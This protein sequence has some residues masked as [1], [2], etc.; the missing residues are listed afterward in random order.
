MKYFMKHQGK[1]ERRELEVKVAEPFI[2]SKRVLIEKNGDVYRIGLS[3]NIEMVVEC[4]NDEDHSKLMELL[5]FR[6]FNNKE[7]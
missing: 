7:E 6:D 2:T 1:R 4:E 5:G 3:P